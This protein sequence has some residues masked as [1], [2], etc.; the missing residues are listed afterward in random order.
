MFKIMNSQM[1]TYLSKKFHARSKI[2]K[3]RSND[4]IEVPKPNTEYKK[5]SFSYQG[6]ILWNKLNNNIRMAP[7]IN[8]FKNAIDRYFKDCFRI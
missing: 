5:R 2:Y 6:A 8:A 4:I 7:S 3:T 1:P